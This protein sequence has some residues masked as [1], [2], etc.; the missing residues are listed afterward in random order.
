MS[1]NRLLRDSELFHVVLGTLARQ[2]RRYGKNAGREQYEAGRTFPERVTEKQRGQ[3][4]Q[5]TKEHQYHGKVVQ[6]KMQVCRVHDLQVE[7]T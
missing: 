3:S 1:F 2:E 4:Q 6:R 7:N 5:A